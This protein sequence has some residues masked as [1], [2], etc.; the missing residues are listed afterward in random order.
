MEIELPDDFVRRINRYVDLAHGIT[1][2]TVLQQAMDR[3]ESTAGVP[4]SPRT[5]E[6]LI[7]R[8]RRFRG[9][10]GDL[11]RDQLLADRRDGLA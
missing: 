2:L 10:L 8:F 6:E 5:S 4:T 3:F 9:M 7:G 1:P 11:D